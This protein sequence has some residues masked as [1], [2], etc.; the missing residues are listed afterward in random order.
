MKLSKSR[1]H[2]HEFLE[3][4][5]VISL[6]E[7]LFEYTPGLL[8][9][10]KDRQRRFVYVNQG[11]SEM[12]G[13]NRKAEIIGKFDSEYCDEYVE[14]MFKEDDEL[15]LRKG[16]TIKN[17]IELVTTLNG[18]IKW[19]ITT[20]TPLWTRRGEVG[21]LA[22][23]TR[24]FESDRHTSLE[25]PTL[26]KVID[27]I[28]RHYSRTLPSVELASVA[29]ISVSA[30][31]RNFKKS[32]HLTPV[33]YI[34]RCRVSH[35]SHLLSNTDMPIANIASECGFFDQ[36]HFSRTFQSILHA[37]PRAYRNRYR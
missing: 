28:N 27:Y 21:G 13:L 15:I 6:T 4:N 32:F 5:E 14:S 3:H 25:H 8:F 37:T 31:G 23:V 20:K 17:K 36:S 30:L 33:Q 9:F 35:A 7:E 2:L 12:F 22:G 18:V 29:G 1:R 24:E 10:V 26:G 34:S 19:H 16:I 11:L